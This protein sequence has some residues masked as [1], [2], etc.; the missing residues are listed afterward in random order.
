M[1][2][3]YGISNLVC[4]CSYE[5]EAFGRV[6]IEAQS[7]QIPI[8]ASDIGGSK[9]TIIENKTGYFFKNKDPLALAD[10]MDMIMQKNYDS[11]KSIGFEGR[12]N[13]LKRF[14]VDKMCQTTLTEYK[15]LLKIS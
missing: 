2:I 7:M 13:V 3:A 11:L 4:S 15:K 10:S 5:P 9:E 14:D 1:P 8:L 6:S 12:K